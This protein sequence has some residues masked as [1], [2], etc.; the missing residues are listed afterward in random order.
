MAFPGGLIAQAAGIPAPGTESNR[1]DMIDAVINLDKQ[2]KAAVFLAAPKTVAN[3]MNHDW[4]VDTLPATSTAGAIEGDAWASSAGVARTRISNA[5]QTFVSGFAVSLDQI[6][7]SIRGRTPGVSNEYEHQLE[8]FLLSLE[9]SIDARIVANGASVAGV[10][11]SSATTVA[12]FRAVRGWFATAG[13]ATGSVTTAA[14]GTSSGVSKINV[15]GAWSRSAFMALHEAMYKLGADPD[16]LAVDPGVKLD[17]VTDI[18]GEVAQSTA[19]S[20]AASA[21]YGI[22]A[23]VRQQYVNT[24]TT[25]FSQD[26]QFMRTPFGRVAVLVDRFI[27]SEA[28]P[29]ATNAVSGGAAFLYE[30]SRLRIAFWRPMRHYSIP[31]D[32][33]SARGYVHTAATLELLHP[34]TVGVV[35]GLTT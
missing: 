34:N 3:G 25:D 26:V 13:A 35:Y 5:V 28:T 32:G 2:K 14:V 21:M 31:P 29:I 4:L 24:S 19:S 6:E 10:S 15:S 17:I 12:L 9:Q 1:E 7:Y 30:R 22:P 20:V 23:V 11:A 33:D 27:P 18:M 8:R 16:T